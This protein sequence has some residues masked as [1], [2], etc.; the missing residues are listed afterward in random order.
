MKRFINPFTDYGFKRIFGQEINKDLL[1]DF[2]NSVVDGQQIA[3]LTFLKPE[4]LGDGINERIAV[5]DIFCENIHGEKFVVEMQQRKQDYFKDRVLYYASF[6]IRNQA[7][8]GN[9]SFCQFPV[10]VICFLN[11]VMDEMHP[12]KYR[13]DVLLMEKDLKE[14]FYGKLNFIFFE[15]PKFRLE[16]DECDTNYKKWL[17]VLNNMSVLDRLPPGFNEQVFRKLKEI[18]D[19]E[20]M[21][22]EE[23]LSYDLSWSTYADYY[24]TVEFALKEGKIEGKIEGIIEGKIEGKIEGIIEG[25]RGTALKCKHK[26]MDIATIMEVTGLTAEEIESL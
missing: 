11:F 5:F 25:K 6:P 26:G 17:Y 12:A 24:N 16:L 18:V 1:I 3:D 8:K 21:S 2:L 10:Y 7:T 9:W 19:V 15:M 23:R 20:H 4:E 14:V 13:W 22:P